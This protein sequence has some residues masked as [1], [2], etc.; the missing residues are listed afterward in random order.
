MTQVQQVRC[1]GFAYNHCSRF[2]CHL[3]RLLLYEINPC[4]ILNGTMLLVISNALR[5]TK[6]TEQCLEYLKHTA[7]PFP[8]FHM[9]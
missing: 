3:T 7:E 1:H 8:P 9:L 4:N 2:Q 6:L 5:L